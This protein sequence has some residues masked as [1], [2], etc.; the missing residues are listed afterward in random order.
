MTTDVYNPINPNHAKIQKRASQFKYQKTKLIQLQA[1][2]DYLQKTNNE[3][4]EALLEKRVDLANEKR[5]LKEMGYKRE[6]L[7]RKLDAIGDHMIPENL[8]QS[9][10]DK[11]KECTKPKLIE[12]L[13][14]IKDILGDDFMP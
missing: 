10:G 1:L 3:L 9:Y 13:C 5:E 14:E 11:L 12:I 6:D 4:A 8:A 7:H 2:V